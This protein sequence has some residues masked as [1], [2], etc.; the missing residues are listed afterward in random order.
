MG[1]C[2]ALYDSAVGLQISQES[3]VLFVQKA[4]KADDDNVIDNVNA[5]HKDEVDGHINHSS[6]RH[7]INVIE[8]VIENVMQLTMMMLTAILITEAVD[9][10]LI[11]II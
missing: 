10:K 4:E 1:Y 8:N 11:M 9:M 6:R 7:Q 2:F 3:T 5:T